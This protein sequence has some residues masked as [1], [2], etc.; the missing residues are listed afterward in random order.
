MKNKIVA[1]KHKTPK[2]K[3]ETVSQPTSLYLKETDVTIETMNACTNK[4]EIATM[5]TTFVKTGL[6][7]LKAASNNTNKTNSMIANGD[8]PVDD[9]STLAAT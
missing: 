8:G 1:T 9:P 2:D 3:N 4:A 6:F 7:A 5:Q